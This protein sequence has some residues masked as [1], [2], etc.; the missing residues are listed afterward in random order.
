VVNHRHRSYALAHNGNLV[1]AHIIRGELEEQ[2]SIFQTTMDSE[3]FLH[4]F[5]KN[6]IKGDY[7]SAILK[8]VSKLEGAYSMILLT[9][10]GEIIGM[11][12]PNGFR[13]LALGKLNG[14]YVLASETCAFDLIQAEFHPGTG[15]R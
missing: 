13:P 4:L 11:K 2:G 15:P 10:K 7:E 9:C 8:A 14:H 6:L 3:V 12:D 5:I 1:N